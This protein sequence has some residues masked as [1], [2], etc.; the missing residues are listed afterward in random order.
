MGEASGLR[1]WAIRRFIRFF[2]L[3]P[4][5]IPCDLCAVMAAAHE[6]AKPLRTVPDSSSGIPSSGVIGTHVG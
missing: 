4:I 6:I 5:D 2:S 1:T 3:G